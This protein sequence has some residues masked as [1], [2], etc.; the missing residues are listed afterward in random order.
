MNAVRQIFAHL[1]FKS[2]EMLPYMNKIK[3]SSQ[4]E[5]INKLIFNEYFKCIKK[6]LHLQLSSNSKN[7]MKH[8]KNICCYFYL[9]GYELKK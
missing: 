9:P 4:K 3:N 1:I 2:H 8:S 5:H 6:K 7:G